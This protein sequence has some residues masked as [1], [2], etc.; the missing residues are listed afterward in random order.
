MRP[1]KVNQAK[2]F[3]SK[4][5]KKRKIILKG[6]GVPFKLLRNWPKNMQTRQSDFYEE[7]HTVQVQRD[8]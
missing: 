4:I 5:K 2:I 6:G 8:A 3:F 7:Y 1:E